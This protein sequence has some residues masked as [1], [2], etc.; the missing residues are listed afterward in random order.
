MAELLFIQ[1]S[2]ITQTTVLGGNV[3][4][5]K[6]QFCIYDTQ[7]TFI[8]PLLGTELYDKI[9]ADV[10]ATTIAG[11]YLTLY[12]EYVK[13]ITK[14]EALAKYIEVS[15]YML[16]NGGLFKHQPDNAEIV[17]KD[18]AQFLAGK[19]HA[20]AQMYVQRFEKWICKNPLTEYKTSQD[21][22]NASKY[23][24]ATGGLYFGGKVGKSEDELWD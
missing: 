8:E 15:S 11:D 1:P 2:E 6:Y 23:M 14:N 7:I 21:D 22:V 24:K 19:Y 9:I 10:T 5:D 13:P 12:N 3:D 4:I 20:I 17:D 16:D 18:E